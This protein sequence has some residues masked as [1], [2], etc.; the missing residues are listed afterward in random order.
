[1]VKLLQ[2]FSN[3]ERI[4]LKYVCPKPSNLAIKEKEIANRKILPAQMSLE[5]PKPF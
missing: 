2:K 4:L 1:M 5:K 3:Q